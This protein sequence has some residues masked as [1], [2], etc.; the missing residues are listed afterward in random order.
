M[1]VEQKVAQLFVVQPEAVT[2]VSTQ[3]KAGDYTRACLE[4]YPVGGIVYFAK[5]LNSNS[6]VTS[7]TLMADESL[8][9]DGDKF[10]QCLTEYNALSKKIPALEQEWLELSEKMEEGTDE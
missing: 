3:T 9:N 5:N 10:N 2:Q 8:Y 6:Q 7:M 4:E 1:T